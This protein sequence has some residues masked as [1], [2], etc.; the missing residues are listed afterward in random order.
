MMGRF[1]ESWRVR[2]PRPTTV[3]PS[4]G[5]PIVGQAPDP[6][7]VKG[8]LEQRF[9][10]TEQHEA[11]SVL[12]DEQVLLLEPAADQLVPGGITQAHKAIGPDGTVWSIVR[13]P[14]R[15]RRR[16]PSA[17]TRYLALIVRRATDIKEK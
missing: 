12:V 11:G 9:P 8:S 1:V 14:T 6:I 2:P 5:N 15:R 13:V 16:R 17:P 7:E 10:R 4:T 3:D